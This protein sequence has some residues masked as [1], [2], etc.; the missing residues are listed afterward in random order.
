MRWCCSGPELVLL[1]IDE[2]SRGSQE[3]SRSREG[4]K[5][6]SER[7]SGGG[8]GRKD[9]RDVEKEPKRNSV[10]LV[11]IVMCKGGR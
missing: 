2:A 9:D 1:G 11:C 5:Q 8:G 6:N 7:G 4:D 10:P 3:G